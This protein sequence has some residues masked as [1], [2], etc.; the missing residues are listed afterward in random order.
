MTLRDVLTAIRQHRS[1]PLLGF[2]QKGPGG[3]GS[4]WGLAAAS[5]VGRACKDD[6]G[7]GGVDPQLPDR[8]VQPG[9]SCGSMDQL[10][11]RVHG[12]LVAV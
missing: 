6:G 11:G 10:V 12:I 8:R 2:T 4:C 5:V 3:R 7:Y 9:G 1:Y